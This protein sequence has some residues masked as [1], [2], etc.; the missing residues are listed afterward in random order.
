MAKDSERHR[1]KEKHVS[2]VR[3]GTDDKHKRVKKERASRVKSGVDASDRSSE[4]HQVKHKRVKKKHASRVHSRTDASR[5]KISRRSHPLH[6]KGP[7]MSAIRTVL[8]ISK[9]IKLQN[10]KIALEFYE[11]S[12]QGAEFE[13]VEALYS[14]RSRLFLDGAKSSEVW[15]H[16]S[17]IAKPKNVDCNSDASP[18]HFFAEMLQDDR[19][20]KFH[21]TY[22]STYE[23]SDYPGFNHECIFCPPVQKFH[24]AVGYHAGR[25]PWEVVDEWVF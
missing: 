17:F 11:K 18:K 21:A 20:A 2:R 13:L 1:V 15:C 25:L 6:P 24:P 3:R 7:W 10:A 12:H 23:P 16:V 22:C 5:R 4:S 19:T 9:A 14:K 8:N